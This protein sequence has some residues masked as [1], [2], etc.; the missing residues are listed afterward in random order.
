[1]RRS[2]MIAVTGVV[3]LA[4]TALGATAATAAQASGT[5]ATASTTA[6]TYQ[7]LADSGVSAGEL[8]WTLQR[9]G[10]TV[11]ARNDA[12]GLVTVTSTDAAFAA[13]ART[14]DGVQGAAADRS[15]GQAP[16]DVAAKPDPVEQE[17]I[18]DKS[19]AN[20][21]PKDIAP[22]PA[23]ADPLDGALWGLDMLDA[24]EARAIEQGDKVRVGIL[25]TGVDGSHLDIAPNFDAA[26]SRNFT[27]DIPAIDGPCEYT[28][29][30]DPAGVDNDGHGTHVAGTI[31]AALNGVGVSGVAPEATLVNIRGGQDSGYFF[32]GPV[33]DAL[34]Y[35][36]DNGLDVVNMSFY[37]DPWLYNCRG[38]APEDDD[39]S[40]EAVAEQNMIIDAM[41]RALGYATAH[42]VALVGALGNN[43]EDLS[44]PR[45]DISSPDYDN[46]SYDWDSSP[47]TRTIDNATCLDLPV[48]GSDVIG[49]SALGPSGTK[50]D[51]SNYTTD[52]SS[53]E[54]EVSAPG[55]W[56]RDGFGT[57][58]YR[59]NGNLILSA[60]PLSVLQATGEVDK[61]G[62]VTKL[63]RTNGVL[64]SCV[65]DKQ[66]ENT[67]QCAYYQW[68][69]G[70]SMAAPHA[71]GVAALVV[72]AHGSGASEA[73]FGLAPAQT[74]AILMDT[75]TDHACPSP[76]TLS[77]E[78]EGR[79]AEFTATCVGTADFNGFY[80][81][82]IVNALNA[83]E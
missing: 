31:G 46:P 13:K 48:E 17:H 18:L 44:K 72:A 82:G 79:S 47:W 58:G 24:F 49:V 74:R 66:N 27:T 81:D 9:A 68:L 36:G 76:G 53:G 30:V 60:A 4:T 8:A 11:V 33:V 6:G 63:G 71:S 54:I 56:Y 64:K 14:L 10:A 7:V 78:R 35:A 12:I 83:V 62:N 28:G 52:L 5:T 37:V 65:N 22:P 23:G 75:A 42:G 45:P 77:Y 39:K 19:R 69:Q 15:I 61:N 43:H 26:L 70:T 34:T 55:G 50:S 57:A 38:G 51:F 41:T 25:D 21:T 80:G 73:D 16:A 29:C 67:S 40:P 3:A 1:M 32:L 2:R 20:G 59:T